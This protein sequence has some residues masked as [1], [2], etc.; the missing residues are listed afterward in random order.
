MELGPLVIAY[1]WIASRRQPLRRSRF[2]PVAATK[3]LLAQGI[4]DPQTIA[5][6]L[7]A[8]AMEADDG[9]P[10]DDINV[11]CAGSA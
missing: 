6:S 8:L 5:D 9:R 7:L 11:S 2:D 1:R 4:S 10:I 3:R